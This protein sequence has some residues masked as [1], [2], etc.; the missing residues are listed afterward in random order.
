MPIRFLVRN[1]H[2]FAPEDVT[3]LVAAFEETLAALELKNRHDPVT[4][5]VAKVIFEAAKQGELDPQRL[6]EAAINAL[7]G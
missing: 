6:R 3:T 2:A 1:D 4:L 5:L 7:S